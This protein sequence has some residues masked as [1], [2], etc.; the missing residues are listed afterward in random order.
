MQAVDERMRMELGNWCGWN[1]EIG[2]SDYIERADRIRLKFLCIQSSVSVT[3]FREH[4]ELE[5]SDTD[6]SSAALRALPATCTNCLTTMGTAGIL[7]LP[8]APPLAM[9]AVTRFHE[10]SSARAYSICTDA[11]APTKVNSFWSPTLRTFAQ[12]RSSPENRARRR[13]RLL[14]RRRALRCRCTWPAC[15]MPPPDGLLELEGARETREV[16]YPTPYRR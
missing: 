9:A 13:E 5:Q 16:L 15:H 7:P 8:C 6:S 10:S 1:W 4:I 12:S 14:L 2:A 3:R 11:S